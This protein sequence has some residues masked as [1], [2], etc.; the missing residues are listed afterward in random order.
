M[1]EV[2]DVGKGFVVDPDQ[3][4]FPRSFSGVAPPGSEV[5]RDRR[6]RRRRRRRKVYWRRRRRRFYAG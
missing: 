2:G 3:E 4:T 5:R 6:R 1:A